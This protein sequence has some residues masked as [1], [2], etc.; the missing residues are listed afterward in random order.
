MPDFLNFEDAGDEFRDDEYPDYE[1]DDEQ[2]ETR[3]CNE[4]GADVYEESEQCPYCG[5]YIFDST[6]VFTGRPV[7]WIVLAVAGVI[8]TILALAWFPSC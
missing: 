3:P 7:W 6:N 4:C 2:V 8:A 5:A 1:D